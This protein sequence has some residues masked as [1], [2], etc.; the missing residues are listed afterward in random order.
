MKLRFKKAVIVGPGLIG[1]SIGLFLLKSKIASTVIGVARSKETLKKALKKGA[2]SESQLDLEKAIVDA[3]LVII[4][5]PVKAFENIIRKI[6]TIIKP[7]SIVFD[8]GSTKSE[9]VQQGQKLLPKDVYF[10]GTHPMAGS[11]DAGVQNACLDFFKG[12]I[13][14]ITNTKKTQKAAMSKVCELWEKLGAKCVKINPSEHDKIVASISHLP[15]LISVALVNSVTAKNIK[16]A[17]GGFKDTTRIAAGSA[18]M[19]H[20]ITLSNRKAILA[21]IENFEA[22]LKKMKKSIIAR[23]GKQITR[24]L[25][26]AREKRLSIK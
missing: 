21:Q 26:Q 20:D 10:V 19:W 11:E 3:D 13:C 24:Q 2:I 4:C 9:I 18:E 12:S 1:G 7:G 25:Q 8:V 5:T 16:F 17:A 23:Q 14:F 6:R 22:V 15:H